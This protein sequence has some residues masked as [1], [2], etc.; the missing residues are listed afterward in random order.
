S[1]VHGAFADA[2][3]SPF[4]LGAGW[5]KFVH[6]RYPWKSLQFVIGFSV[7]WLTRLRSHPDVTKLAGIWRYRAFGSVRDA[8][9]LSAGM[10]AALWLIVAPEVT[11]LTGRSPASGLTY[12]VG[13]LIGAVIG[14]FVPT[15]YRVNLARMEA[16]RQ[17]TPLPAEGERMIIALIK[18]RVDRTS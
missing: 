3:T 9:I 5:D 17:P 16:E 1:V 18:A 8:L 6:A 15:W 14:F 10:T 11:R 4:D 2:T 13:M 7:A 12:G